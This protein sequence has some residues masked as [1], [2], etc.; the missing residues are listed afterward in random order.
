MWQL[1][2]DRLSCKNRTPLQLHDT[3]DTEANTSTNTT[4][5]ISHFCSTGLLFHRSLQVWR[6]SPEGP[7][8]NDWGL[9]VQ[10]FTGW[11]PFLSPN[12]HCQNSK[13]ICVYSVLLSILLM[14]KHYEFSTSTPSAIHHV[15]FDSS[16]FCGS[17]LNSPVKK[18]G[19]LSGLYLLKLS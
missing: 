8:K 3:A 2:S 5:T 14:D 6:G 13:G 11:M 10:Y 17:F 9:L 7:S 19:K 15:S 1:Y 18:M 16:L 12:K 4:P